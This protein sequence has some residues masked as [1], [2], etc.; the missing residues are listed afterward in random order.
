MDASSLSALAKSH[1]TRARVACVVVHPTKV[2][3][4]A[5]EEAASGTQDEGG[6]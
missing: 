1:L 6:R 5:P 2:D 3:G 4:K